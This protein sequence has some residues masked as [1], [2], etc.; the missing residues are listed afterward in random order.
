M[1]AVMEKAASRDLLTDVAKLNAFVRA[2]AD[3]LTA[4]HDL[5]VFDLAL[6]LR[7]LRSSDMTFLTSPSKGTGMEGSQSVVY[8]DPQKATELYA[9]VNSDRVGAW[10]SAN[11]QF[12]S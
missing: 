11:P 10:L 3:S 6:E 1:K 9:A 7:H 8:A 12:A 2:T 5:S 4:D